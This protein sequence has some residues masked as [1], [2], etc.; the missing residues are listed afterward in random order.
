MDLS[1]LLPIKVITIGAKI[2]SNLTRDNYQP[3][4]HLKIKSSLMFLRIITYLVKVFDISVVH[5]ISCLIPESVMRN[6]T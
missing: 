5:L 6:E 1:L 4:K 2:T 3:S